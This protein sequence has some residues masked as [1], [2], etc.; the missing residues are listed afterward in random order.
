MR[1]DL[2]H[3][4]K[5]VAELDNEYVGHALKTTAVMDVIFVKKSVIGVDIQG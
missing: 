2:K 4:E 1:I 3:D 5:T